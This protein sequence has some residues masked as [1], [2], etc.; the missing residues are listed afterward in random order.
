MTSLFQDDDLTQE[1]ILAFK[2]AFALVD[3]KKKGHIRFK[4]LT[5]VMRSLGVNPTES[6]IIDIMNEIDIDA[7]GS[8]ELQE[9]IKI[10]QDHMR[11]LDTAE[12]IK[13][14]F[15]VYDKDGN[16]F[17]NADEL[18]YMMTS[19]CSSITDEEVDEM[20]KHAD[21][22]GDGQLNYQEFIKMLVEDDTV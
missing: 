15:R 3:K 8:I 22:D 12:E 20:L 10:M 16:G 9:F 2:E 19:M 4:D 1:Q 5:S 13:K 21:I 7:N 6:E 18:K 14:V 17:L 11:S